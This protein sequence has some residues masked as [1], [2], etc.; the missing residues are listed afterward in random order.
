[1]LTVRAE[2]ASSGKSWDATIDHP[3][4]VEG[5][6]AMLVLY[7]QV[8]RLYRGG[9]EPPAAPKEPDPPPPP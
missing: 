8:Q 2:Y 3:T 6:E 9:R 4:L 1:M 7:E 5:E